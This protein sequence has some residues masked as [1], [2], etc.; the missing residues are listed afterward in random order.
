MANAATGAL[1]TIRDGGNGAQGDDKH[2][3]FVVFIPF[4]PKA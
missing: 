4:P 2:P 3:R 1:R